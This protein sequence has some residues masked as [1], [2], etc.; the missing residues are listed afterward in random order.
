MSWRRHHP[1]NRRR[2]FDGLDTCFQSARYRIEP[3]A[4][5]LGIPKRRR[6]PHRRLLH[7]R[8][9]A[10]RWRAR[11]SLHDHRHFSRGRG[12]DGRART[13]RVRLRLNEWRRRGDRHFCRTQKKT[14]RAR[15]EGHAPG[16]SGEYPSAPCEAVNVGARHHAPAI[17]GARKTSKIRLQGRVRRPAIRELG[18]TR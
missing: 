1:K 4:K 17:D 3:F 10:G 18:S 2:E 13:A 7:V 5:I 12:R 14:R 16:L 8:I 15:R 11:R 9:G 6:V